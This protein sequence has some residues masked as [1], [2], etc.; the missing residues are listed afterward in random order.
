MSAPLLLIGDS[1]CGAITRGA[2]LLGSD[3]L[4]GGPIGAASIFFHPF[5]E[6]REDRF[7]WL[8]ERLAFIYTRWQRLTGVDDLLVQRNRLVVSLGLG[9]APFYGHPM[10]RRASTHDVE[11]QHLSAQL[12]RDMARDAQRYVLSFY[13]ELAARGLL[14]AAIDGPPPQRR[15]SAV[16]RM[17]EAMA[18]ELDH[19]FRAPVHDA[20]DAL[21]VPVIRASGVHDEDGLLRPEFWSTDPNHGNDEY[22]ARVVAGLL[23]QR[24]GPSAPAPSSIALEAS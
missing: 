23:A 4:I 16:T 19:A 10:W 22:G 9:T 2:A 20:L 3:E 18:L 15:H 7:T 13:E 11:R 21:G 6:V 14:F 12:V 8:H 17:G 24:N 1:H 5:F